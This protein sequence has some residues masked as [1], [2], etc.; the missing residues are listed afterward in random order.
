MRVNYYV[1]ELIGDPDSFP[2]AWEAPF[3]VL[4]LHGPTGIFVHPL[5]CKVA[6]THASTHAH[7]LTL[8]HTHHGPTGIFVH[9]LVCKVTPTHASTRART[10]ARAHIRT[11]IPA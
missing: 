3:G 5:V 9:P 8:A 1:R 4:A 11:N 6:P 7:A 2:D 10:H